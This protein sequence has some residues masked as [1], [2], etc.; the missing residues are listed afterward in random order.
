MRNI[1]YGEAGSLLQ[2]FQQETIENPS[3]HHS[4][5]L[6]VDEQI[7]NIF[8]ADARMIMDYS[9]FGD[10]VTLDTTYTTN[11]ACRPLAMFSGFNH[12]KGVVVF[13]AALLYDEIVESFAW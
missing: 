11:N 1:A 12:F 3:F 4:V 7:T 13:E 8:W 10:V 2:Y 5:Q 9:Y 6:Y